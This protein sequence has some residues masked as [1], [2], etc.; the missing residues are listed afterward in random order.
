MRTDFADQSGAVAIMGA[1]A[2]TLV[3]AGAGFGVE[4]GF[5]FYEQTRMQ[6]MADAAAYAGT[7]ELRG[8]AGQAEIAAGA[9]AA[10]RDNGF[11]SAT[12][13]ISV[14]APATVNGLSDTHAVKVTVRRNEVRIF[15]ALFI[16]DPAVV[17]ADATATFAD[18]ANACILALDKSAA[19][20]VEFG[21]STVAAF[22]GCVVMSNSIDAEAARVQG[23]ADLT[24]PCLITV[25]GADVTSGAHLTSCSAP[26]ENAPPAADPFADIATPDTNGACRNGGGASLSPGRY[27]DGLTLRNNVTLSPG[28]YVISGGELRINAGANVSGAGVTFFLTNNASANFNGNATVSL[29]APTTGTYAGMLFMGDRRNSNIG[30]TFNGTA[31]SRMTG[32]LYFPSQ[33]VNYLGNFSGQN[34]CTRVVAKTVTWSGNSTINVDC[35]GQG[36]ELVTVGGVI[37]LVG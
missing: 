16:H 29:T 32:A 33:A 24:A 19:G 13:T 11:N 26:I 37:R 5:W 35:A 31:A 4:T 6:Q 27:C 34:G 1:L 14:T 10:A 30:N 22:N 3:V 7:V 9:L 18:S 17:G 28:V 21:G 2:A 25:G 23:A 20:A 15:S 8:G 36:M 12:D